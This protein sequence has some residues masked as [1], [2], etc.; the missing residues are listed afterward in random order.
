MIEWLNT[1]LRSK[2]SNDRRRI[3]NIRQSD[4]NL[5]ESLRTYNSSIRRKWTPRY[6]YTLENAIVKTKNAAALLYTSQL[7]RELNQSSVSSTLASAKSSSMIS[8]EPSYKHSTGPIL[9]GESEIRTRMAFTKNTNDNIDEELK[10]SVRECEALY[11]NLENINQGHLFNCI[12]TPN[13]QLEYSQTSDVIDKW[14]EWIS[15][16]RD[17]VSIILKNQELQRE[18]AF[19]QAIKDG[20]SKEGFR[21][22]IEDAKDYNFSSE[23]SPSLH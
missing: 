14:N 7:F 18:H 9:E 3:T 2:S 15:C 23:S 1:P 20:Y 10:I 13:Y 6:I 12:P 8:Y 17:T 21:N 4:E 11:K 5:A 16:K 19:E 22:L